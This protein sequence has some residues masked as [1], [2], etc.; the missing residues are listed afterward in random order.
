M[1]WF[2]NRTHIVTSLFAMILVAGCTG[3]QNSMNYEE[4][5]GDFDSMISTTTEVVKS[6]GLRVL[7]GEYI[8]EN[9]Y[10]ITA[11]EI[12]DRLGTEPV[13]T[14]ELNID[15]EKLE[16]G[17]IGI[18]VDAPNNKRYVMGSSGSFQSTNYRERIFS[19]LD[20]LM[21]VNENSNG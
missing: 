11:V 19:K 4:Y 17:A 12:V 6:V 2:K 7:N 14:L 20:K 9:T 3:T 16:S 10:Q 1:K 15:L 13:Q 21:E 5:Q 18:K 8:D